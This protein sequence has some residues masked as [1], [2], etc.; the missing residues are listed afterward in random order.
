MLD[1]TDEEASKTLSNVFSSSQEYVEYDTLINRLL[2]IH[3]TETILLRL[4]KQ[5]V[6]KSH[7]ERTLDFQDFVVLL[8]TAFINVSVLP[9]KDQYM[10]V[11]NRIST[12]EAG[13]GR[14]SYRQYQHFV[15]RYFGKSEDKSFSTSFE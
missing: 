3:T 11:F 7:R 10:T 8:N 9:T 6:L 5:G 13:T 4:H 12:S 15:A 1:Q 2:E 14:I